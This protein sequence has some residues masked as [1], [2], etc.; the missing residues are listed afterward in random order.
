[1]EILQC[2]TPLPSAA[3]RVA[4]HSAF[5]LTEVGPQ[6]LKIAQQIKE[7]FKMCVHVGIWLH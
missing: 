5:S 1:M 6:V 4:A 2:L 7:L 3:F